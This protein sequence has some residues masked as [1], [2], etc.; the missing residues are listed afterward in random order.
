M[1]E[2]SQQRG[3][4]RSKFLIGRFTGN[5][6]LNA[7]PPRE[8]PEQTAA[9]PSLRPDA[10][11]LQEAGIPSISMGDYCVGEELSSIPPRGYSERI[12]RVYA[13]PDILLLLLDFVVGGIALCN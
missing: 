3:S 8:S 7:P 1:L 4:S 12:S 13:L 2:I 6:L 10:I 5:C 11:T 9:K